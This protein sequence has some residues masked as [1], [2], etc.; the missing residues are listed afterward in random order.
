MFLGPTLSFSEKLATT[1]ESISTKLGDTLTV[2]YTGSTMSSSGE[3]R[4][5]SSPDRGAITHSDAISDVTRQL[6]RIVVGCACRNNSSGVLEDTFSP[7]SFV[8]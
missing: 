7:L 5:F 4:S 3:T 2:F 1:G 8:F 6:K